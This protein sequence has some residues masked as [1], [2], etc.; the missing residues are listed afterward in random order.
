VLRSGTLLQGSVTDTDGKPVSG[1][2]VLLGDNAM[3]MNK[4][5]PES[6]DAQGKFTYVLEPGHH[7]VLTATAPGFAPQMLEVDVG[8]KTQDVAFKM[9]PPHRIHGQVVNPSGRGVANARIYLQSW[10]GRQTIQANF[11]TD[12]AGNFHWNDA[13]ADPVTVSV[14]APN[15][16]GVNDAVLQPD[17]DN[18]VKLFASVHVRGT[19]TDAQTGQPVENYHLEFGIEFNREQPIAWQPGWGAQQARMLPGGKFE[20]TDDFNYPGIAVRII[21]PGYNPTDSKVIRAE[22]GDTT[23][24]LQMKPGKDVVAVVRTPDGKPVSG[25]MAVLALP[26]QPVFVEDSRTSRNFGV[27]QQTTGDD[28]KIDF[29]PQSGEFTI[30][31][32]GDPGYAE[33]TSDVLARSPD[34]KLAP[35]GKIHGK[36][37]V[38][39]KPGAGQTIEVIGQNQN[40]E[41]GKPQITNQLSA[42]VASDGSFA[43][44]RV[45]PGSWSVDRRIPMANN[46]WSFALLATVDV[47]AG[48]T[49][50]VNV[51]GTGRP[52]EGKIVL[53]AGVSI[54]T[55]FY[56]DFSI[57]EQSAQDMMPPIPDDI[58]KASSERQQ[59][60]LKSFLRS[61]AGK[62]WAKKFNSAQIN[63]R[64]YPFAPKHDGSFHVDDVLA[65]DYTLVVNIRTMGGQNNQPTIAAAGSLN[66]TVPEMPGG[67][68]DE[69]LDLPPVQVVKLE[70]YKPGDVVYDLSLKS[71]DGKELKLSS[72]RG[73]FLLLDFRIGGNQPENDLRNAFNSYGPDR[74]TILS[75]SQGRGWFNVFAPTSQ[76]PW[77]Q[78]TLANDPIAW[79]VLATSFDLQGQR[80]I[81]PTGAWLLDP[82]GAVVAGDLKGPALMD[83]LSTAL[84]PPGATTAPTTQPAITQ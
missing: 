84:G 67:R 50:T 60:W 36:L 65:G 69:P 2:K 30:A 4:I 7:A 12:G 61:D 11:V 80:G 75:L 51:G 58:K 23:L 49:A 24:D 53:P 48:Q 19:V 25:A 35:W 41:P 57:V 31:V 33:V 26:G 3:V 64:R 10:N 79:A 66:F 43:I 37:M 5:P 40:Y 13:P 16:R 55:R 6:T 72:F 71:P 62:A 29:P 59:Q 28:G 47:A 14:N 63:A 46:G 22:D 15:L 38:G 54:A 76:I 42:D 70:K 73:K 1:A 77:Q 8:N 32:F 52:V 20:F 18:V 68:S 39:S 17:T 82:N 81:N 78:A 74:L 9:T 21:A 56:N 34:I 27:P 45:P 44:D 83:A